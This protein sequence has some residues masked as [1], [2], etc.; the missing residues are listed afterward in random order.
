MDY[1]SSD[2]H[3]GHA[4]ILKYDKRE[5]QNITDHDWHI[6]N[7]IKSTLTESDNFYYIG[8]WCLSSASLSE[9]YMSEISSTG[10]KLFFIKGNHDKLDT[11][12][13]YKKYGAF[14]GEQSTVDI[15][16]EG[17]IYPIVLNHFSMR[18][19]NRSHH[20]IY[21]L[22]GHSHDGLDKHGNYW[23]RSMDCGI[24]SALRI[25]GSYSLFTFPEIHNILSK[26][27]VKLIDHHRNNK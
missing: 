4:N 22:Y 5:F 13:L 14:L 7:M 12:K 11:I 15:L 21:H 16:H 18:I 23:G 10:A 24:M 2:F 26:R 20:G 1:F 19:W 17:K 3:L 25:K 27:D 9:R 8:D 6:I